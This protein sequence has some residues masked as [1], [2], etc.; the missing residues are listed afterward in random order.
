MLY[1]NVNV[2]NV[3]ELY[4]Q[5]GKFYVCAYFTIINDFIVMSM[6]MVVSVVPRQRNYS[7][8]KEDTVSLDKKGQE[9]LMDPTF[10]LLMSSALGRTTGSSVLLDFY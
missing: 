4:A 5:N 1:N 9:M 8:S 10:H 7:F 6:T 2:F 3:T